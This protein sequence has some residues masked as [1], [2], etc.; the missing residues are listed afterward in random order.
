MKTR[1]VCA[2][3]SAALLAMISCGK[4]GSGGEILI[5][6]YGSLTGGIATFGISTRDGSQMA[7]DEINAAGGVL[8]KKIKLLVEDDQSKPEEASTVVT[9]LINQNHVVAM[10][11]HV[12][13]SHSLAAAPICQANKIP[14]ITPSSTNPRVTQVGPFIFRVCFIDPFQG[15]VMAKFAADTLK[16]KKVAQLVDVRSDYSIGLQTFFRQHFKQLG[17]EVVSEQSYSQG[18]SDFRAQ[19][20]QIKAANPEAIYVPGYYTEVGTIARQARELGITVPLLGGDGWDSPKLW[21]IGG[22]ALNGCYFSNH[23]ST[24]DPSPMVQKFVSDYRTRFKQVPDALA[25]LAYDAARVMA[26]AIQRA[27]STDGEKVRDAIAATK[28]FQGV[29]GTIT[30]NTDRNAVKPAVVLKVDNGKYKLV[31]TIKPEAV[32]L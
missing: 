20:T 25:A 6:E 30:I 13:S 26:D 21:E 32:K 10:L 7:L 17:G 14:M 24:D 5:G 1:L 11:G 3:V 31:E 4:G 12:A 18:D 15:A 27:G 2:L 16:V 8:G 23:Y 9:K 22:V 29:T 19:L 28:D